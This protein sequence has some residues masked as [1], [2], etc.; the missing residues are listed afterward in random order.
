MKRA[1]RERTAGPLVLA[2]RGRPGPPPLRFE[3]ADGGRLLLRQEG[4]P[5]LLGRVDGAN[6]GLFLHHLGG[7]RS[8]LPPPRA[9]LT[10][11]GDHNPVHQYARWLEEAPNGP[12]HDA[13]WLLGERRVFPPYVWT[14]DLVRDWPDC[15][16]D[17]CAGGWQGVVPLRPLSPPDAP[18]VKAYRRQARE[19]IL[20]PVLLWSVTAL[21]GWLILD[22]HDR[23]V[24]ALAEGG[25]P[26]CVVLTRVLDEDVWR[27]Q[28]DECVEEH[29]RR[30][31]APTP[32]PRRP[33]TDQ[34]LAATLA[35]LPYDP[36]RTVSWPLPGGPTAW[37]A[38]AAHAVLD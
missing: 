36:A 19:G 37:D 9:A 13:R 33:A 1:V 26:A 10:R 7:Y 22:G 32:G 21:D 27:R 15:Y 18:R 12:L 34:A 16:L 17:W 29:L 11:S 28:P 24:A 31:A 35:D 20:A 14:G 8:P 6:E 38:L 3:A 5:V 30:T 4:R 23:A 2:V 25:D